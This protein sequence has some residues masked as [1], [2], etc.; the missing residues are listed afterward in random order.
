MESEKK[1]LI[2]L[3]GIFTS[4]AIIIVQGQ[5]ELSNIEAVCG[6]PE[7]AVVETDPTKHRYIPYMIRVPRCRG[8]FKGYKPSIKKCI[9]SSSVNVSYQATD[10]F[11]G[12]QEVISVIKH[13]KC[14]GEC[15]QSKTS[16]N[17]FQIWNPRSCLCRCKYGDK[18]PPNAC[19]YPKVW[20]E[21][22]CNCGCPMIATKCPARKE[23][24]ED[25]CGCTCKKV[26][27]NRCASK[28]KIVNQENCKCM[29]IEN[30]TAAARGSCDQ[31][32]DVVQNKIVVMIVVI[33]FLGLLFIFFLI[34]R[35][36][37]RHTPDLDPDTSSLP[38]RMKY[39]IN[40]IHGT[41]RR[42]T[43]KGNKGQ[44]KRLSDKEGNANG[45]P[46][47]TIPEEP[48]P[49]NESHGNSFYE[50]E[51]AKYVTSSS[52]HE[53][54]VGFYPDTYDTYGSDIAANPA[55]W[56]GEIIGEE[57]SPLKD[58]VSME[59]GQVTQV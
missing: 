29:K 32:K 36:C 7:T 25:V 11:T 30:K 22:Q 34:Y 47:A 4:S 48:E 5:V 18:P 24:D 33:E 50:R 9:P 31:C 54:P 39:E 53:A 49:D 58:S 44:N 1:I 46:P 15:V 20:K 21:D 41:F 56:Y 35:C 19:P 59:S 17:K 26:H 40:T 37:L 27:L 13:L 38:R 8:T 6:R 51:D 12:R 16:C 43:K 28:S 2:I 3:L 14:A 55:D 23:W 10:S 57:R 52:D 42:I 45:I